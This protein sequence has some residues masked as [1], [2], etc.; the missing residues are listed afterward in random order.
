MEK[1][2]SPPL[3]AFITPSDRYSLPSGHTAAAF[4]M[5]TIIGH[6]YP[7]LSLVMLT[8]ALTIGGSRIFLGVH[9]LSD[10]VIGALLGL[11]Q[12]TVK[13]SA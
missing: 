1:Y 2:F 3:P 13:F 10:V 4:L 6:F 9:F 12:V 5:A 8:W 11:L 7:D